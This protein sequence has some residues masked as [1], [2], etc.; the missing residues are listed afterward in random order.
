MLRTWRQRITFADIVIWAIGMVILAVVV[1]GTI[2]TLRSGKYTAEVW[3]DLSMS[4]LALGGVYALIALGY[5]LVYGILRM[6][7]FAHSEVFM[8]GPFTA[9]F[10]AEALNRAGYIDSQPVLSLL[11]ITVVSAAVSCLIAI[12]LERIAYRPLRNA[13]R[14]VPLITAIGA[15]FFLQYAFRGLYGSGIRAYPN[16]DAL[17]GSWDLGSL[18]FFRTDVVIII[19]A[20]LMMLV[21]YAIVQRTKIGKAMRAVSEDKEVAALMG[22][23]V[24]RIIVITFALGGLS[25][26]VAGVL[27]AL[28]FPVVNFYMGFIPG[29]K[30]FTAAVLG[31]IGNVPGAFVGAMV[32]GVV[33]SLGPNLFLDGLGIPAANQLKDL[34]AFVILVFIL[35]FRP[36]GILGERL[37]QAKA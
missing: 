33:E 1:V 18:R 29:I 23:N 24:D 27:Y 8:S 16:I 5:T 30:A 10:V 12:L 2:A 3:F 11:L 34:V 22:I 28:A 7:N 21:L 31:G 15:S 26:G 9:V 32:L 6:I 36:T 13:P 37:A 25:A 17:Q 4:G 20:T 35:I 14:L 19:S